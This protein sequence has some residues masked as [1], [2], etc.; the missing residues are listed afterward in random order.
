MAS[1]KNMNGKEEKED[2]DDYM[3]MIITEPLKPRGEKET[4][5]QRRLR[6]EREA[7]L[8]RPK[9]KAELARLATE[10]RERALAQ[11][12]HETAPSSKGLKMM[13]SMGF[14]P[15]GVLGKPSQENNARKEPLEVQIK[16]NRGGIGL[17]AEKKRKIREEFE[18]ERKRVKVEEGEYRERVR[19][20][21]E[22]RKFEGLVVAAQK[23]AE[24]L[25]D[26]DGVEDGVDVRRSRSSENV[27]E[28]EEQEGTSTK[29]RSSRVDKRPLRSVNVLWR[30]LVRHRLEKDQE[31]RRRYDLLQSLSRLPTYDDPDEDRDDRLALGR[32]GDE[33]RNVLVEDETE[34]EE[35]SELNEFNALPPGERLQKLVHYLR[36]KHHYCFWCKY[37]YP[38]DTMDGCPGVTEED[39]D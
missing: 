13:Q 3:N 16:E 26:L 5:T 6:K 32:E 4:Y 36:D 15:G 9:S 18:E 19:L 20:E 22:E 27:E 34:L 11:P 1:P 38:D 33:K 37:Q 39:H 8:K 12:L 29:P 7:E 23:V 2:E 24:R 14:Q 28:E 30:G 17:D 25:D 10:T 35:D 21:R 31:R